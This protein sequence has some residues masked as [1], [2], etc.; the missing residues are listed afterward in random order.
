[1]TL[2]C[3]LL[4]III[5]SIPLFELINDKTFNE[6]FFLVTSLVTTTGF[7]ILDYNSNSVT[8]S[9]WMSNLQIIGALYTILSFVLYYSIFLNKN[10]RLLIINKK[11]VLLLQVFFFLYLIIFTLCINISY[12][13]FIDS[14]SLSS[15]I[16]SSGGVTNNNSF[17]LRNNSNY[18]IISFFTLVSLLYLPFFLLSMN[19]KPLVKI[20][21]IFF[22]RSFVVISLLFIIML[23]FMFSASMSFIEN[24]YLLLSFI[25]TT[26]MMPTNLDNKILLY[27][28]K[29][30]IL[31]FLLLISM[32]T[33]SGTSNGGLKINRITLIFINIKEEFNKFLFQ[34]KVKG[35]DIIKKGISQNE[36]NSF[37][38]LIGLGV[39]LILFSNLIL[40]IGG[41]SIEGAFFYSMAALT[42]TGE[43]FIILSSIKDSVPTSYYFVLNILM[44]CGRFETIGYLLLFKKFIIKY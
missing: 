22:K 11:S 30:Y 19:K 2:T 32:G 35:V 5:G 7:N 15:A 16:L 6:I 8:L 31:F 44:I 27:E 38:S 24:L 25:T 43:G 13:N 4:I 33:F 41:L 42:N 12:K 26:G 18:Y 20:F 28:Y 17:F 1:M 21:K 40:N 36:L 10:N 37:Y 34:Y 9:V 39:I 14:Y 23:V 3:W 29:N